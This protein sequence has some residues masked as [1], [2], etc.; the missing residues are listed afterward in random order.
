MKATHR[1]PTPLTLH[2][3]TPQKAIASVYW[4]SLNRALGDKQ[5]KELPET[6]A[7]GHKGA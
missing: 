7:A 1:P 6:D 2:T 4:E 3:P 5:E